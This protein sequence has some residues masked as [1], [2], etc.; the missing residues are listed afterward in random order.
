MTLAF[1]CCG[2]VACA[3][4]QRGEAERAISPR[5]SMTSHVLSVRPGELGASRGPGESDC[6]DVHTGMDAVA[7]P[8]GGGW[9]YG[10]DGGSADGPMCQLCGHGMYL[11]GP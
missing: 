1:S 8:F 5:S 6:L 11:P 4:A 10:M 7:G 2:G 9:L 3:E